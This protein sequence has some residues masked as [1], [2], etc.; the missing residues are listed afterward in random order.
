MDRVVII[1]FEFQKARKCS[2]SHV[3]GEREARAGHLASALGAS[4]TFFLRLLSVRAD[5][6]IDSHMP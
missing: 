6:W 4:F 1:D 5:E 2:L 3:S